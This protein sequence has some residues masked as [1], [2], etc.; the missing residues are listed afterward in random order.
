MPLPPL[1]KISFRIAGA[2]GAT[3]GSPTPDCD[4]GPP[5]SEALVSKAGF[6]NPGAPAPKA[7]A[8]ANIAHRNDTTIDGR[9]AI[10]SFLSVIFKLTSPAFNNAPNAPDNHTD[11]IRAV[12]AFLLCPARSDNDVYISVGRRGRLLPLAVVQWFLGQK[13]RFRRV[14]VTSACPPIATARKFGIGSFVPIPDSCTATKS[15]VLIT[16]S[17]R[18]NYAYGIDQWTTQYVV[19]PGYNPVRGPVSIYAARFHAEC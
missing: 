4:A 11:Q 19:N 1:E 10:C 16:S 8:A 7:G 15:I 12:G 2:V 18:A 13:R 3:P 5:V 14:R 17:P 6:P 9:T